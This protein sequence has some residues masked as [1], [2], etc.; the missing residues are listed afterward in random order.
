MKTSDGCNSENVYI[1]PDKDGHAFA[2][3]SVHGHVVHIK[4]APDY[5]WFYDTQASIT[6]LED[7]IGTK[8]GAKCEK[9]GREIPA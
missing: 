5:L 7:I 2:R 9:C 4:S 1:K 8:I 6:G 3:F